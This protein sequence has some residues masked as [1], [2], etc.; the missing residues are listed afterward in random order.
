MNIGGEG[1]L[2][3]V[4]LIL[5]SRNLKSVLRDVQQVPQTMPRLLVS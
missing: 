4:S 5:L 2:P 3:I 1:K